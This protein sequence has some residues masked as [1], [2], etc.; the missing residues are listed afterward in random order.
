[1]RLRIN[2]HLP[3]RSK[4][5]FFPSKGSLSAFL[6][7][8]FNMQERK[9]VQEQG[10]EARQAWTCKG[11]ILAP[12]PL[13]M[14]DPFWRVQGLHADQTRSRQNDRCNLTQKG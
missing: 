7:H 5:A 6:A 9:D 13:S 10:S 2:E 1:M 3:Y 4:P 11:C 8:S 12:M 14:N